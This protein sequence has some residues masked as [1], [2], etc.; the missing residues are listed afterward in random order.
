M[1]G[2][3]RNGDVLVVIISGLLAEIPD[4]RHRR[5]LRPRHKRPRCRRAAEQRDE[6]AASC[7]SRKEHCEG[8]RGSNHDTAL[9]ATGSPQ[10]SR[11]LDRE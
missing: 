7:M 11:K 6:L 3:Q 10:A 9:V 1:Q 4:H 5:L 2:S 8:R